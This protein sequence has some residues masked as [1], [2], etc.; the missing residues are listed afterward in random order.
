MISRLLEGLY[1]TSKHQN[2]T[3]YNLFYIFTASFDDKDDFSVSHTDHNIEG[4][5][6]GVVRA[7]HPLP[8]CTPGS[9]QGYPGP[10]TYAQLCARR[11]SSTSSV[12]LVQKVSIYRDI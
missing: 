2:L 1:T 5:G 4:I 3:I 12:N 8:G 11:W 6:V 9:A 10:G 7:E